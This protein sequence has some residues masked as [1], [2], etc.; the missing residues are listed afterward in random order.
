MCAYVTASF[1]TSDYHLFGPVK[2]VLRGHHFS[3][4]GELKQSFCDVLQS[5]GRELY[6]IGV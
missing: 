3:D 2:N 6:N 5:Q 4:D 1:Q